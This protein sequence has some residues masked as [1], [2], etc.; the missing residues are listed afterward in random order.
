MF[1]STLKQAA[2]STFLKPFFLSLDPETSHELAKNL[3]SISAKFPG[4]LTLVESMTSYRSDR[5]KTRVAGIEFENPLGMG[6]GFDKTGELYPFLSRMGFG[7][8]EIGTITGKS[9]P[10]NLKPRVFRYPEDQALI[11]HMGFNNPGADSAERIIAPQKKRKIRGINA[12]KTKIISEEK[13]VEDYIYTLKKLSPYADYAVIN[14]SS[15]NTPG[16][17]DFQKQKNFVS[18]IQGIKNGLGKNFIIPL[19]VKFAPDMETKDLEALLE[20]S[21]SLKIDGVVL[22]NTTIDKSSLKA[23]PNVEKEGG[24]SGVPLKNR[25]TEFVRVAYRILKRRIPIIGVGGIDSEK[26]ALEKILAGADLIQIYT[27]YIYQ[28]PFLPLKILEFLD[29]F[30]KEQDLKTVSDLVGKEKE[31]QYDPKC[32]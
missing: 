2:Y 3:L 30:L 11:N 22:T 18:L 13:A 26:A 10:G 8:I 20:S 16:L 19:F 29:R 21:L 7:H 1:S 9:Q 12:G 6:A 25:S 28:G 5:L 23:Y 24:L 17:R 15:P 27:G 31:I 14:I 32:S 4:I